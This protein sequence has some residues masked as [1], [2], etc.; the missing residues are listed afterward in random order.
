MSYQ[1]C[2]KFWNY[3]THNPDELGY[4]SALKTLVITGFWCLKHQAC[5]DGAEFP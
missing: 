2:L 3:V 5:S 4:N 1:K